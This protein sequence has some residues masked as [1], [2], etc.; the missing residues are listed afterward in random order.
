VK[1][2]PSF[3]SIEGL[4]KALG[5]SALQFFALKSPE[6]GRSK[7]AKSLADVNRLLAKASDGDLER[8]ARLLKALVGD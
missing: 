7:R 5:M 2:A 6:F 4:A 3:D 1:V 8:F